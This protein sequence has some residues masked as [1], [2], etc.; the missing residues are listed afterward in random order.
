VFLSQSGNSVFFFTKAS[1]S[2]V[3]DGLSFPYLGKN[4]KIREHFDKV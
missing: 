3:A 1:P 2:L 4:I